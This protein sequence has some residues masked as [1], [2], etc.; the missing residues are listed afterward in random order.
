MNRRLALH[1]IAIRGFTLHEVLIACI[2]VSILAVL[3]APAVNQGRRSAENAGCLSNLRQLFNAANYYAIDNFNHFPD[4]RYWQEPASNSFASSWTLAPYLNL[5]SALESGTK[6]VY[7]CPTAEAKSPSTRS[8]KRTYS[9]S[10]YAG[11]TFNGVAQ[12][13]PKPPSLAA[14]AVFMDGVIANSGEYYSYA[15]EGHMRSG[16]SP[17]EQFPHNN[18]MNVVFGD[19]HVESLVKEYAQKYLSENRIRVPFWGGDQPS[20]LK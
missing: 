18:Q 17:G 4:S 5:T 10:Q 2:I 8:F 1:P 6:T 19:G 13:L 11:Y 20:L 7:T 14:L 9:M 3:L 12:N 16:A 15:T